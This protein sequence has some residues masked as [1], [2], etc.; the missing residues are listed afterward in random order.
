[1]GTLFYLLAL[2]AVVL[3]FNA[4]VPGPVI[5]A[6]IL[7]AIAGARFK[8]NPAW[9]AE[10]ASRKAAVESAE[11][12]WKGLVDSAQR[13]AR[14]ADEAFHSKRRDLQGLADEYRQL[15]QRARKEKDSLHRRREELQKRAF[16][17][18]HYVRDAKL[19]RIGSELKATLISEGFETAGDI[20]SS[21]IKVAGIGQARC[22]ALMAWRAGVEQQFRFDPNAGI[23]PAD[24]KAIDHKIM[25]RRTEIER[26]LLRGKAELDH[27][28]RRAEQ[29]NARL[30]ART[31]DAARQLA[32]ARAD[33]AV[34]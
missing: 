3:A 20:D 30:Q 31:A 21:V 15:Q 27:V 13:E 17:D 16:L 25:I 5:V 23:N 34:M 6:A 7:L 33:F 22:A 26:G 10:R 32:Q 29:S 11:K 28:C 14:A 9:E 1:M 19:P 24:V 18:R 2:G 12:Q 8:R 4:A